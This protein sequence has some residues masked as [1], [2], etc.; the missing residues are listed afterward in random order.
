MSVVV[1][2]CLFFSK[3][4]ELVKV[5]DEKCIKP[6]KISL[7]MRIRGLWGVHFKEKLVYSN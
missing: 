5:N 2:S 4:M 1:I 6:I 7:F 3:R